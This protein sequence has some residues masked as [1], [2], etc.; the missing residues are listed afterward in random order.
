MPAEETCLGQTNQLV[1][2]ADRFGNLLN[3]SVLAYSGHEIFQNDFHENPN[4]H[5]PEAK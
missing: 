3:K 4:T 1:N 2:L 5:V